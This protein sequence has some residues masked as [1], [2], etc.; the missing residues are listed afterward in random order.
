MEAT[1]APA[2]AQVDARAQ[3]HQLIDQ[4][5]DEAV[6]RATLL[7]LPQVAPAAEEPEQQLSPAWEKELS[8]RIAVSI[9]QL[10]A[11]QG[12]SA[13]EALARLQQATV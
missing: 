12:I 6:L 5:Q 13:H 4:I 1:L 9:Q 3:L 10:D 2:P 8:R 7:L 11:G